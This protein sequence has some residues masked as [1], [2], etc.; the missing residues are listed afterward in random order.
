M[1]NSSNFKDQDQRENLWKFTGGAVLIDLKTI[2]SIIY[3]VTK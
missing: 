3:Y 2:S 1:K